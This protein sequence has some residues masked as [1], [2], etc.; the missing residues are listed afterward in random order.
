LNL[1]CADDTQLALFGILYFSGWASSVIPLPWLADRYGRKWIF[2]CSMA[3]Q[4]LSFT[5][6]LFSHSSNLS[7]VMMFTAGLATSGRNMVGY[8]F[9]CEF[10]TEKY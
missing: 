3:L 6:L 1:F 8:V 7:Y 2:I 5:I 9:M 10:L 4:S